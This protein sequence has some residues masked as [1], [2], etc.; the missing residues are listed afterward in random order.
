MEPDFHLHS[1]GNSGSGSGG[2]GRT[3]RCSYAGVFD[4]HSAAD[5]AQTA[6]QRLH[7]ILAGSLA[8]APGPPPPPGVFRGKHVTRLEVACVLGT[9]VLTGHL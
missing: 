2:A 5:A 8:P 4:G 7:V 1:D 3:E 6:A 9:G